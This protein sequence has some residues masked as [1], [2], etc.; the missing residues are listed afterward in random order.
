VFTWKLYACELF[1]PS[2]SGRHIA[3]I[4]ATSEWAA[5]GIFEYIAAF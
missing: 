5:F 4:D 2:H 1:K 3:L